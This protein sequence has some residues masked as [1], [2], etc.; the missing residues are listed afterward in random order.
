MNYRTKRA[1]NDYWNRQNWEWFL[2]LDLGKRRPDPVLRDFIT[3]LQKQDGIQIATVGIFT[4]IPQS[5]LHLLAL[6]QSRKG[7]SLKDS[8]PV[9]WERWWAQKVHK[10]A[11]IVSVSSFEDQRQIVSYIVDRN[12]RR[13][14]ETLPE[15][16]KKLL[17]RARVRH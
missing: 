12:M 3:T 4:T 17:K 10:S 15:Y 16:N 11:K 13:G 8:D 9:H 7:L 5:H 6:G 14:Y 1:W 2:S